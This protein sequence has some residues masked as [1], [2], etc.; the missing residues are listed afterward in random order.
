MRLSVGV[1]WDG[2]PL[3][4]SLDASTIQRRFNMSSTTG[5]VGSTKDP[6]V[7]KTLKVSKPKVPH[8][9]MKAEESFLKSRQIRVGLR[10][11]ESGR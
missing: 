7:G 5:H 4:A 10:I 1:A 2:M 11:D 9:I 6:M 3:L 8:M